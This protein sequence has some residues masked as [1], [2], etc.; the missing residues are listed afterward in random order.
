MHTF[1]VLFLVMKICSVFVVTKSFLRA[2]LNRVLECILLALLQR[3]F[4]CAP[5]LRSSDLKTQHSV[6]RCT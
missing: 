3:I 4:R 6:T 1:F 2:I 5:K